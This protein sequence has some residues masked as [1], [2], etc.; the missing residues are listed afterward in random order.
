MN[1]LLMQVS[2]GDGDSVV[3]EVNGNEV[4][5]DLVLAS[6]SDK[7]HEIAARA[8]ASLEELLDRVR[9]TVQAV[10]RWAQASAPDTATVE[11]GLKLGGETGIMIAK[12]TTEVNF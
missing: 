5:E 6:A 2:V 9:P 1:E 11:F 3:I 12:G 4:P 8:S 7:A 10:G